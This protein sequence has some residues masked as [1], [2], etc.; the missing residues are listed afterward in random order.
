MQI[1]QFRSVVLNQS[2]KPG[3]LCC[4]QATFP[5]M[6]ICLLYLP[7]HVSEQKS[8]VNIIATNETVQSHSSA[9]LSNAFLLV[10]GIRCYT[11]ICV[12]L[13]PRQTLKINL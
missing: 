8:N 4:Y 5:C 1:D 12:Q 6:A 9:L 7:T 13:I 2:S 3:F 10:S 11:C